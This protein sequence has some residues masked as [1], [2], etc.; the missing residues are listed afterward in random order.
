MKLENGNW[1]ENVKKGNLKIVKWKI[2]M[3]LYHCKTK[4]FRPLK[5]KYLFLTL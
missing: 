3:S 4:N 1:L 5:G 2:Q